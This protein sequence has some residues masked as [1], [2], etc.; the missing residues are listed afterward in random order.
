MIIFFTIQTSDLYADIF[1]K[2]FKYTSE[3]S[4]KFQ[5]YIVKLNL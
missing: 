2:N 1:R 3:S 5:Q 4:P